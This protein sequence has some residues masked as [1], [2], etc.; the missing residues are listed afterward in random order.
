[1]QLN[2]DFTPTGGAHTYAMYSYP[3]E[4][5]LH[6][7]RIDGWCGLTQGKVQAEV[8]G[9]AQ[10]PHLRTVHRFNA[11]QGRADKAFV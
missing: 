7:V 8:Q 10:H 3:W 11:T 6:K 9:C 1:M 5:K 2:R 4:K